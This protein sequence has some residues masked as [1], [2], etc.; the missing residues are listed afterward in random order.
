[1]NTSR[2]RVAWAGAGLALVMT[3]GS[4]VWADDTELLVNAAGSGAS[5]PNIL[6]ILDTSGSMTTIETT[7]EPFIPTITY[8]GDC[9]SSQLYWTRGSSPPDCDTDNKFDVTSFVCDAGMQQLPLVVQRLREGPGGTSEM[10]DLSSS[11]EFR[12]I[13]ITIDH[14]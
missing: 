2:K 7:Q 11:A 5:K 3:A 8:S 4:P 9:D 13:P 6:F 14:W 10:K 12:N 1:M